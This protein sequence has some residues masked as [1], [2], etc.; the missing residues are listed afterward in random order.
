MTEQMSSPDFSATKEVDPP[1]KETKE[2]DPLPKRAVYEKV[3]EVAP[4]VAAVCVICR[5]L[6]DVFT[7]IPPLL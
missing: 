7:G 4:V 5:F 3:E 1:G 6:Y 2:V